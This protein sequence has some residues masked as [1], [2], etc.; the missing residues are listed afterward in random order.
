MDFR[1]LCDTVSNRFG[2]KRLDRILQI[3]THFAL[4]PAADCAGALGIG[5]FTTGKSR[6][7]WMSGIEQ[8]LGQPGHLCLSVTIGQIVHVDTYESRADDAFAAKVE[9]LCVADRILGRVGSIVHGGDD[10]LPG[11]CN[12]VGTGSEAESYAIQIVSSIIEHVTIRIDTPEAVEAVRRAQPPPERGL[13]IAGLLLDA[14]GVIF[15]DFGVHRSRVLQVATLK[16]LT[17]TGNPHIVARL[18]L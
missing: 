16:Y 3:R 10:L 13:G 12:R 8:L 4:I 9:Q 17:M 5:A 7:H 14:A 2:N 1:N 11:I 15:I 6:V 18:L